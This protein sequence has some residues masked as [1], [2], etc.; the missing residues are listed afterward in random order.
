MKNEEFISDSNFNEVENCKEPKFVEYFATWCPHCQ[1]MAPVISKLAEE[2]NG[3]VKFFLV[4]VDEAPDSTDAAGVTG[5]PTMFFFAKDA[6]E[7][8][9]RLVGEKSPEELKTELNKIA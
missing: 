4:D 2:Y 1:R 9:E 8:S 3:K 5:T 7:H 6:A